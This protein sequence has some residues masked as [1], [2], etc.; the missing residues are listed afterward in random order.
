MV[1]IDR[2]KYMKHTV[3]EIDGPNEPVMFSWSSFGNFFFDTIFE[4]VES[5]ELSQTRFPYQFELLHRIQTTEPHYNLVD[6]N[7]L[8]LEVV[9]PDTPNLDV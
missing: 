2:E 8:S 9:A 6:S 3:K 1:N 5:G 4:N 7:T